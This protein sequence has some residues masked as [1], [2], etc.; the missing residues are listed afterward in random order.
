MYPLETMITR[1]EIADEHNNLKKKLG[2]MITN[3]WKSDRALLDGFSRQGKC[4]LKGSTIKI[5]QKP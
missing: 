1:K 3:A 2:I 4:L 5:W